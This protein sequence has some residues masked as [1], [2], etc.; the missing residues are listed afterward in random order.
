MVQSVKNLT[1]VSWVTA[2]LWVQ[3]PAPCTGLKDLALQ[4][5][6]RRSHL[7]VGA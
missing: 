4:Q 2:E 6:W 1:A 5:F 3:T 7:W